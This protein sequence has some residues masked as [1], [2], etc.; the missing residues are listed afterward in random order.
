MARIKSSGKILSLSDAK[1]SAKLLASYFEKY[2]VEELE[3]AASS[4]IIDSK[5]T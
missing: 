3:A 2:G 5:K 1:A 4:S